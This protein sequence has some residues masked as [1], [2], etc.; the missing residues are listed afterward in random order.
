MFCNSIKSSVKYNF[1]CLT[2]PPLHKLIRGNKSKQMTVLKGQAELDSYKLTKKEI[3][4][5]LGISMNAVRMSMRGSNYHNL[6]HR[7]VL[8]D[9][10]LKCQRNLV[11]T[12]NFLLH[13]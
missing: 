1:W 5:Y 11:I 8:K 13:Q 9:F 12:T 6:E 2:T 4:D 7:K 3:A 10:Y